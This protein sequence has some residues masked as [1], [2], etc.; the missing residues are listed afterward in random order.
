MA[1]CTV[2]LNGSWAS[3]R[4]RWRRAGGVAFF[5]C[6]GRCCPRDKR[7]R[8]RPADAH[9]DELS[10]ELTE[11]NDLHV[12]ERDEQV[13]ARPPAGELHCL[14][15][16]TPRRWHRSGNWRRVWRTRSTTR[17]GFVNSQS[18]DARPL[19]SDLLAPLAAPGGCYAPAARPS[20]GTGGLCISV[21][22][23]ISPATCRH[24]AETQAGIDRVRKIVQDLK[25]FS[26]AD[27]ARSAGRTSAPGWIP[28]NLVA[29]RNPRQGRRGQ[30]YGDPP[31]IDVCPRSS[32]PGIRRT[33]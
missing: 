28:L 19:C 16:C 2:R 21:W 17:I 8:S 25:D 7:P 9:P 23:S 30:E 33:C 10:R 20:R 32:N 13:S 27:E 24:V 31:M 4:R 12:I 1:P 26:H 22:R 14:C 3:S 29:R 15:C 5:R 11:R 6:R 18:F